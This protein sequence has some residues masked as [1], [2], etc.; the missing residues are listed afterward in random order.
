LLRNKAGKPKVFRT[1]V[2]DSWVAYFIN[3]FL[4]SFFM[5]KQYYFLATL[6]LALFSSVG[7]A[8]SVS[9]YA[10]T[11][12]SG[13]NMGLAKD[14]PTFLTDTTY[15]KLYSPTKA[16][17]MPFAISYTIGSDWNITSA[18]LRLKAVDDNNYGYHCGTEASQCQD[19]ASW[20]KRDPAELAVV[21]DI[22]GA[23][24]TS[25]AVNEYGWYN[26]GL[27][28][29]NYLTDGVLNGKVTAAWDGPAPTTTVQ[30]WVCDKW[31]SGKCKQGHYVSVTKPTCDIPDLWYKNVELVINYDLKQV[32]VPAAVWLFGSALLG[33]T[34]IK[35]KSTVVSV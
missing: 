11:Y 16:G 29:K 2:Q 1:T 6:A 27:D 13:P 25:V 10:N 22:E 15:K 28:V 31:K 17:A 24:S 19:G 18:F 32:P 20:G 21:K 3:W 33:L 9:F 35:R 23:L 26:L 7:S 30:E 14:D 4:W 5:K 12:T 8:A 34:G